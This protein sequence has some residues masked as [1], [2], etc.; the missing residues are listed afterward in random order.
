MEAD[1]DRYY[2]LLTSAKTKDDVIRILEEH[3]ND[4]DFPE[5]VTLFCMMQA[6]V[7]GK[8]YTNY[9]RKA[10]SQDSQVDLYHRRIQ[11]LPE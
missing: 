11:Y 9:S 7:N 1:E 10:L 6:D 5:M 8:L 4:A 3:K 2:K